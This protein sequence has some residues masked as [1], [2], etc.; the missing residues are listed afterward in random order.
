MGEMPITLKGTADGILLKPRVESWAVVLDAVEDALID[1]GSFFRGGRLIL[2]V[3]PR[4][5]SAEQ[6]NAMRVLLTRYGIE[7]WA[8]LSDDEQ[9]VHLARSHGLLTRIPKR[10]E[11]KR[12]LIE[13][14]PPELQAVFVHRTLRSGQTIRFPGHVTLV[15]DVNPGAE[16]VAGGNILVWGTLRG[17]AHAG[18]FGDETAVICALVLQPSQLRIAG[19]IGRSPEKRTRR[20]SRPEIAKVEDGQIVVE[21]WNSKRG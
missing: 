5:L 6:L 20:V 21:A 4:E 1:G 14:A 9:T 11:P 10:K 7:L 12:T 19:F 15:G 18:A 13:T 8:V 3:G 16:I 17:V 2:D